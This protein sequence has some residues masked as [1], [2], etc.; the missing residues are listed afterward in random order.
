[1]PSITPEAL[2]AAAMMGAARELVAPV[3]DSEVPGLA[4]DD[5]PVGAAPAVGVDDD[6]RR[7]A[8]TNNRLERGLLTVGQGL[9]LDLALALQETEGDG[10]ATRAATAPAATA[11]RTE[12]AFV[13]SDLAGSVSVSC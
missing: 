6:S 13:G 9:R 5:E 7:H 3:M 8:A 12:V 1:M 10:F 11:P 2:D 4:D